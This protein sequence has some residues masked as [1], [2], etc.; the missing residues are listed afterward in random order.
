MSARP[1]PE[2]TESV[3]YAGSSPAIPQPKVSLAARSLDDLLD[4]ARSAVLRYG[5][6]HETPRGFTRSLNG[7]M[8]TWVAPEQD[9]SALS[10]WRADEIAWYL[11]TFVAKHPE[12]DPAQ[13]G[14]PGKLVF[15]YTYAARARFWDGGWGYLTALIAAM[16]ET[17]MDVEAAGASRTAFEAFL[18]AI[19]ERLHLQTALGLCALYP[20]KALRHWLASPDLLSETRHQWRR[21]LLQQA[22][23]DIGETPESRR[24]IVASLAY[25]QLE[26]QL[27]PRMGMPPYQLF[28]YLPGEAGS[29]LS[30][31]HVHRSLDVDGGAP[32]DFHHDLLWLREASASTGRPVGDITV[33]AHNL[34]M[35]V[36]EQPAGERGSQETIDGWLRRVTDGYVTSQHTPRLL[37][38]QPAY[39]TNVERV[40]EKWQASGEC[41]PSRP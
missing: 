23:E 21:D 3:A 15:P 19:G 1:V 27:Q 26:D 6:L 32:L 11:D 2:P 12:N 38:A 20:L 8:L 41:S 5:E 25:P 13:P 30:S 39:R 17:G 14:A 34:H 33:V 7:V 24:A 10:Q 36:R 16:R 35:Y 31:M 37:L 28:Q 40:W 18:A 4:Q 9:T 22:I 29:P